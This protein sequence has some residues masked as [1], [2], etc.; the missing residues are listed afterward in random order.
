MRWA[1]SRSRIPRCSL[2][3]RSASAPSARCRPPTAARRCWCR[4]PRRFPIRSAPRRAGGSIATARSWRSCRAC[5]PRCAACGASRCARGWLPASRCRRSPCARSRPSASASRP[6]RSGWERCS[7]R[8]PRAS[9]RGSMPGTTACM[10]AS[11][12]AATLPRSTRVSRP[13][14]RRSATTR[15]GP[16]T[17][18]SPASPWPGWER[19]DSRPWPAGSRTPRARCSRS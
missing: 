9:M 12:P 11:R 6:W 15:T 5:R 14:W 10:R 17:T 13:R 2:R 3:W 19:W 1:R 8:R 7:P 16:M 18:T 4:R